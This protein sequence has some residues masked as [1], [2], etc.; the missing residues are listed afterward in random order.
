MTNPSAPSPQTPWQKALQRVPDAKQF[1]AQ[2]PEDMNSVSNALVPTGMSSTEVLVAIQSS[3]SGPARKSLEN[4]RRANFEQRA[5]IALKSRNSFKKAMALFPVILTTVVGIVLLYPESV[6][7]LSQYVYG[8][9][10]ESTVILGVIGIVGLAAHV[11]VEW[12]IVPRSIPW[13]P[14]LYLAYAVMQILGVVLYAIQIAERGSWFFDT[15]FG[16]VLAGITAVG[17]VPVFFWARR[18]TTLTHAL[19]SDTPQGREMDQALREEVS[20]S[21]MGR[22]D[23]D[24]TIFRTRSIEGVRL[25]MDSGRMDEEQAVWML[26]QIVDADSHT[27]RG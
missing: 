5:S 8:V 14:M 20:K 2:R 15:T 27:A 21:L 7:D 22:D 25:L 23:F 17:F 16:L 1:A 24:W 11:F 12:H 26:R 10:G 3:A 6:V 9:G 13:S 19:H 4:I 18:R